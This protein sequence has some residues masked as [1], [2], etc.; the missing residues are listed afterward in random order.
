[1]GREC[2]TRERGRN[3]YR[4]QSENLTGNHWGNV[5][6]NGR[7][8]LKLRPLDGAWNVFFFP[9]RIWMC[10]GWHLSCTSTG[11]SPSRNRPHRFCQLPSVRTKT[12]PTAAGHVGYRWTA[13]LL[14]IEP[15]SV[16]RH[17]EF[18]SSSC[19]PPFQPRKG[20]DPVSESLRSPEYR[21]MDKVQKPV[22]PNK[23]LI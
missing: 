13:S 1:M 16:M 3:E 17:T 8:I 6:I 5:S 10:A 18:A 21:T 4:I 12:A 9:H 20:T 22:I 19:L 7:V 14:Q 15:A 23:I 11:F 2:S